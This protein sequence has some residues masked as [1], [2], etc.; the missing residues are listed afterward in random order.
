MG[1]AEETAP[2]RIR[3]TAESGDPALDLSGLG[4]TALPPEASDDAWAGALT[5]E[6]TYPELLESVIARCWRP[7][8]LPWT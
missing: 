6:Y 7:S 4:L 5:F 1:S 2:D 8:A 3:R